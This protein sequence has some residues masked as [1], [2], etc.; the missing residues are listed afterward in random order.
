MRVGEGAGGRKDNSMRQTSLPQVHVWLHKQCDSTSCT[1][2]EMR[3][4]PHLWT[5]NQKIILKNESLKTILWTVFMATLNYVSQMN[6]NLF[7]N[8]FIVEYLYPRINNTML[9][10]LYKCFTVNIPRYI[11]RWIILDLGECLTDVYD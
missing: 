1:T 11:L 7:K 10:L 3:V 2:R 9:C 4:V 6:Y 5:M 8:C